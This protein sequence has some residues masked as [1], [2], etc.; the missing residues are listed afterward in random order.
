[1]ERVSGYLILMKGHGHTIKRKKLTLLAALF[2]ACS[3]F[4]LPVTGN[5]QVS[6]HGKVGVSHS[7][8]Y[9]GEDPYI[10]STSSIFISIAIRET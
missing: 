9:N 4:V 8:V 5:S 6:A 1:M 3:F 2:I 7:N 10:T